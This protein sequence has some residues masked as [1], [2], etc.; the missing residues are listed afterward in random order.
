MKIIRQNI[1]EGIDILDNR[2]ISVNTNHQD[3]VDT[4]DRNEPYLFSDVQRGYKT[5]SIFQRKSTLDRI[6]SN[7]LLNALKQ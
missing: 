5:Y 1:D 3:Y 4:N 6:D 7:P 2:Q